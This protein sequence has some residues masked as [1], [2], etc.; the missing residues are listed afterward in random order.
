MNGELITWA[1]GKHRFFLHIGQLRALQQ[2]CDAG[3]M[4]IFMRLS[5]HQWMVDD[6]IEPIVLGLVGGQ[7]M[8][9]K[10]ARALVNRVIETE[11]PGQLVTCVPVAAEIIRISVL[12]DTG[13][14][15]VTDD[16]V[17]K[18]SAENDS[19]KRSTSETSTNQGLPLT[20]PPAK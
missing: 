16:D 7:G 5:S 18:P 9:E 15:E 2:A 6:V 8:D 19:A 11:N 13:D 1:G 4:H 3:P 14:E 17:G 20:F 10:D 12:L